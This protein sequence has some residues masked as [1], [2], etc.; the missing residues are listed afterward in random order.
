[1]KSLVI[2]RDLYLK[3]LIS[4]EGNHLIKIITGLRRCGK[5]FL[6][7]KIFSDHLKNKGIGEDH[8]IKVDLEDIR[9]VS[10]REPMTL[11]NHIDSLMKDDKM[12]YILID[13]V[14]NMSHFEDVLNS[15]LKIDNADVYVTGSNSKFLSSDIV[16]EFRGR[17]D[18]IQMYPLSF[19]EYYQAVG[20]DE[21]KVWLEYFTYGGLPQITQ[22]DSEQKKVQYLKN[23]YKTVY[24]KD[25]EERNRINKSVEFDELTKII[26]ST[27][28]SP[29]NPAKLSN[30]FKSQS[31][32][33][34]S[35]ATLSLYLDYLEDSFLIEK[36]LR[37][38]VKGKKYINSLSKFYFMDIGLRNALLDFRQQEETHIMENVIFNELR[39]RGYSVDVGM[40]EVKKRNSDEE[41]ERKQLEVDF[42]AN[43][44][45]KRYYIQSTLAMPDA[46]KMK[47][48]SA[49]LC[50]INDNFKK[51][52]VVKDYIK[53]W[54]NENGIL[55]LG[56]FDFLLKPE[57]MDF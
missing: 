40:V 2:K 46:E 13:E 29:C 36:A 42:V 57:L 15:Y 19:A 49:S 23:L 45:S 14:Q 50:S 16:T 9:H 18:E 52:I 26:A 17:G 53:P 31:H 28:G 41:W 12:Y 8:I 20:G 3:Q 37:Y 21:T 4:G 32:S 39:S 30:T 51:I 10:L 33:D 6:L 44:G 27:I 34:L 24:K 1:M 55:L 35:P 38:D 43:L 22:M 7:F 48:E 47:Q 56:L 54:Y 11:V 25:L 5:S